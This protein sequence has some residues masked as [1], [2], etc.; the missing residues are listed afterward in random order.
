MVTA[1]WLNPQDIFSAFILKYVDLNYFIKDSTKL[2]D[3]EF[4]V[5]EFIPNFPN[6]FE[7]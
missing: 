7:P 3:T 4:I 1:V 5:F 6:A 2:G